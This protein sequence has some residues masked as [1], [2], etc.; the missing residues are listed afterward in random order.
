[1]KDPDGYEG[2]IFNRYTSDI[3]SKNVDVPWSKL[4]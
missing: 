3:M 2:M 1:M 4:I